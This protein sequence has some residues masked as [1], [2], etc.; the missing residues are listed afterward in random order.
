MGGQ[1]KALELEEKLGKSLSLD[2]SGMKRSGCCLLFQRSQAI[3]EDNAYMYKTIRDSK[4]GNVE[5]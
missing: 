3:S 1:E 4:Q 2:D 5:I